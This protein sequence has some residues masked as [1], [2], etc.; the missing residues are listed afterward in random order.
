VLAAV[1]AVA[2][3]AAPERADAHIRSG[4]VAT[5][6]RAAVLRV[7][8]V[9]SSA[10]EATVSASDLALR[11]VVA[12]GHVASVPASSGVSVL[13]L[14]ARRIHTDSRTVVWHDVRL[15]G[16]PA[17]VERG[18]WSVPLVVD[19][20]TT[21]IEGRIWRVRAP[22]SWPW[23]VLGLPFV[24]S[25]AIVLTGPRRRLRVAC[26]I[27]SGLSVIATTAIA[28]GFAAS[29][30]A[31]LGLGFLALA[32]GSLKLAALTHGVVLSALPATAARASVVLA[33]WSGA[34]AVV[35]GGRLLAARS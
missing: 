3:L 8:G 1:A 14:D 18:R 34:A 35:C 12:R 11:L 2:V 17:G 25:T 20:G 24:V 4:I 6:Y 9:P 21:Q 22:P 27:F 10:V 28:V 13:R 26:S 23:L 7:P 31:S 33:L 19:G 15:R 16:L 32:V 29:G 30:S 5:D